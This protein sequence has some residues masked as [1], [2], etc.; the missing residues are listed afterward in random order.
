[1]DRLD[2][3]RQDGGILIMAAIVLSSAII[4]L[5]TIDI[6]FLFYQKRELQ[7]VADL[8]ALAG[9][10]QLVKAHGNGETTCNSAFVIAQANAT[11]NAFPDTVNVSCGR[12]DPQV[13]TQAPY[14]GV[15]VNAT[16]PPQSPANAVEVR[17]HRSFNSFFGNWLT[18]R[19]DARAIAKAE[20]RSPFAV[21]S[22]GS[23]LLRIH[24]GVVPSLLEAIGLDISNTDVSSY[25]GIA[26]ARVSTS[27]LLKSLG[28]NIP[29]NAD[30]GT[31]AS[32]LQVNTP[33]CSQGNCTLGAVLSALSGTVLNQNDLISL[34]GLSNEQLNLNVKLLTDASGR[35]LLSML[36]TSNSAALNAELTVGELVNAALL[37]AN[38]QNAIPL[39]L[40]INLSPLATVT[41]RLGVVEAPSIG[42]GGINAKAYTGQVR[43]YTDVEANAALVRASIPAIV[44]LVNG[45]GTVTDLCTQR[46]SAGRETA[47]I[48]VNAPVLSTCVGSVPQNAI[49]SRTTSCQSGLGNHELLSILGNTLKVQTSF[50]LDAL[51]NESVVTLAKGETITTGRNDLQLGKTLGNLYRNVLVKLL[52][53]LFNQG[54]GSVNSNNLASNLLFVG[55]NVLGTTV[56]ALQTTLATLQTFLNSVNQGLLVSIGNLLGG[57]LSSVGN[58]LSNLVGNVACLLS[59]NYNQCMLQNE[60]TGSSNGVSKVL[61]TLL[62]LVTQLLEPI[63]NT[64]GASLA[65]QLNNLLGIRLGEVDVTLIDLQCSGTPDVRLVH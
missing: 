56:Q 32:L 36:S 53:S 30:V 65:Q 17:L 48:H 61:V 20:P 23:R 35:G 22:V 11:A 57:L 40:G 12:W 14:Y 1:M 62:G 54:Q 29:L 31:L 55:N 9:A 7:K 59:G 47:T 58:L 19:V 27:G 26:N 16:F 6:G 50:R 2:S 15:F 25:N 4:L 37:L 45:E 34:L 43:L 39:D 33:G 42:I 18:Q 10:Q 51:P 49:F 41:T 5:A 3:R 38:S 63:L 28:F 13:T 8:A 60:L 44:D 52:E 64:L 21:F 46:D 24:D